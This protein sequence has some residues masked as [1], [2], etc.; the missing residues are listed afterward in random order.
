M[1][2]KHLDQFN[3]VVYCP[4][5]SSD[6]CKKTQSKTNTTSTFECVKCKHLMCAT[7]K[8]SDST[9][10]KLCWPCGIKMSLFEID[11]LQ[12]QEDLT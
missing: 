9:T 4:Y 3:R 6:T 12:R 10:L 2:F 11:K 8:Y 1:N 5:S 7:Y